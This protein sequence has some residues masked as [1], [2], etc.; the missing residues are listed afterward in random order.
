MKVS[1]IIPN[2]NKAAWLNKCLESCLIQGEWLK[3]I[4]VVDDGSTDESASILSTYQ[5]SIPDMIRT[6]I[7]PVK[8]ANN[9]RNF[10]FSLSSGAYIQWLD[11]D[12]ELY[13]GK[14]K[15]QVEALESTGKD[16]AYSDWLRRYYSEGKLI[17]EEEKLYR[18]FDDFL[19]QLMIDNWTSPNNYLVR[20]E[21]AEKLKGG[22]GWNP[23]TR[24]GQDREYFTMAGILGAK[25]EYV[26]GVF[27]CYNSQDKNTI[28]NME[29]MERLKENQKLEARFRDAIIESDLLADG[30]KEE[31]LK[32]LNTHL[33]KACFYNNE[34]QFPRWISPLKL[35][36]SLVHP[37]MKL[38]LPWVIIRKN[39]QWLL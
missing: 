22:M 28:A 32:I 30:P 39:I 36:W 31:Y 38:F 11:S 20:R 23:E 4:I 10:G 6:Y 33:V 18:D 12:D 2:Y 26:P 1:V 37:K 29:F 24:I 14:F 25:F 13:P 21:F 9:A 17:K 15:A 8:G 27:A 35:K 34:I 16:I 19:Y 3:E 5:D 7:N